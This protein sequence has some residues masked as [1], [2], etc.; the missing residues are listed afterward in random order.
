MQHG[1]VACS[2][3][4]IFVQEEEEQSLAQ[5]IAWAASTA[6]QGIRPTTDDVLRVR[7]RNDEML[8]RR[9][10]RSNAAVERAA[11]QATRFRQLAQQV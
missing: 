5:R 11:Q 8:R 2:D 7:R 10:S 1:L 3:A 9:V 6:Q 4:L